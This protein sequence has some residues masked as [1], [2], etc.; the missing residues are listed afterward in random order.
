MVMILS[1]PA[2]VVGSAARMSSLEAS[3]GTMPTD[4]TMLQKASKEIPQKARASSF[5][6]PAAVSRANK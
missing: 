1:A 6:T 3:G 2:I 5:K 4:L